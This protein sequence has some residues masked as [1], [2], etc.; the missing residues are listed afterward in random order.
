M[1]LKFNKLLIMLKL[2]NDI[3]IEDYIEIFQENNKTSKCI[4]NL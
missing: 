3:F 1:I 4:I 2:A